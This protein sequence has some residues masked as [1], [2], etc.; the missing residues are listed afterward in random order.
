MFAFIMMIPM[1]FRPLDQIANRF[2]TFQMGI[3]AA[4]R[5]F[6][7]LDTTSQIDDAGTVE[8]ANFQ[9][10]I[11]F[12]KVHFTY[13]ADQEVLKGISFDV[14]SWESV[15]IFGATGAVNSTIINSLNRFYDI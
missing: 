13:V 7:V 14:T 5:V 11:T 2:N 1:L 12:D 15:A 6:A 3:V 4:N 10:N 8:A 9:G